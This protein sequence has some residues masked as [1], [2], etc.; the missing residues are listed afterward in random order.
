MDPITQEHY[1]NIHSDDRELQNTAFIY[2]MGVTEEP[3]DWAYD[4]WD[5][6][7]EDLTHRNNRVRVISAQL[8]INLA[9]SDPEDRML[10]DFDSLLAVTRDKRFVTARHCLQ[11]LWKV[12]MVG[13]EQRGLVVEG[14]EARYRECASEK[15]STLIRYDIIQGLR[16]LYAVEE[17][18]KVRA[19]ALE[20][21]EIEDNLKYRKKY[22]TVWKNA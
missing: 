7:V 8:L 19:K 20:L 13:T 1:N 9:K 18:E 5:E 3:V 11:N 15:N 2:L 14:L 4:V 12:G 17:E 22:S 10:Q 6:L 21:I 16:N